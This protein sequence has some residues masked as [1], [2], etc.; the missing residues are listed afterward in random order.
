MYSLGV[1]IAPAAAVLAA[2]ASLAQASCA[3]GG[4]VVYTNDFSG[5]AGTTYPEW[6]APRYSWTRNEAGTIE[7]GAGTERVT[8]VDSPNGSQRFLGELG[9]P[10]VLRQPPYDRPH[11]VR[12]DESIELSLRGLPPHTSMTLDFDLYI[13]KSWDGDSPGV[14]PDRWTLRLAGAPTLLDA[15]FSNN[16]KTAFEGSFQSY[17]IAGSAPQAGAVAV[18]TLGYGFWFGDATYHFSVTVAH[19]SESAT[20]TFASSLFEG[21]PEQARGTRDESW[22]LDNVRVAVR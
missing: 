13:L 2:A 3:G 8:N 17:P 4:T 5:P 19:R 15:T 20:W 14:G 1:R 12:V 11:F 21:K 6:S 22:G 18:K 7:A 16:L 10:I 9:G